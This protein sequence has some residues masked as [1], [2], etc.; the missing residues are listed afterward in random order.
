MQGGES[1]GSVSSVCVRVCVR[2]SLH[3][4][5][6]L[7][8]QKLQSFLCALCDPSSWRFNL[9][10]NVPGAR[11]RCGVC[12]MFPPNIN[13]GQSSTY[14]VSKIMQAPR[15]TGELLSNTSQHRVATPTTF[16]RRQ[17]LGLSYVGR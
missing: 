17:S 3:A 10:P 1:N 5:T 4:C 14:N 9:P 13:Q 12:G 2:V 6:V 8:Y 15:R 11:S 16:S 7:L